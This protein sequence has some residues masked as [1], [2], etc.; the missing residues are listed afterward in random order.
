MD[1][2]KNSGWHRQDIIAAIKKRGHTLVSLSIDNEL[3]PTAVRQALDRSYPKMEAII[4]N[5]IGV[6]PE[7]LWP[8]RY[9]QRAHRAAQIEKSR[10]SRAG[11]RK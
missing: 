2:Q 6:A 7:E 4:A 5:A 3:G 10:A 1:T 11:S 9:E 8:A